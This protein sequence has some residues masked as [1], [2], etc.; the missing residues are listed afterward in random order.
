MMNAEMAAAPQVDAGVQ[1]GLPGVPVLAPDQGVPAGG[2]IPNLTPPPPFIRDEYNRRPGRKMSARMYA[3]RYVS[4][5]VREDFT[6]TI[7]WHS[8][9]LLHPVCDHV[10]G[11][12]Y[13]G[14]M[15]TGAGVVK[16]TVNVSNIG[17]LTVTFSASDV[18]GSYDVH[19]DAVASVHRGDGDGGGRF[20]V[21][22]DSTYDSVCANRLSESRQKNKLVGHKPKPK[23]KPKPDLVVGLVG[24]SDS[25]IRVAPELNLEVKI[26][27]LMTFDDIP[28]LQILVRSYLTSNTVFTLHGQV[29]GPLVF[30]NNNNVNYRAD[31]N[32]NEPLFLGIKFK[33]FDSI[34]DYDRYR[35]PDA[36]VPIATP[37]GIA[38]RSTITLTVEVN[39]GAY[40]DAIRKN[41]TIIPSGIGHS[42]H[43]SGALSSPSNCTYTIPRGADVSTVMVSVKAYPTPVSSIKAALSRLIREPYG[44]FEQTSATVYPMVMALRYLNR[45]DTGMHDIST[46]MSHLSSGYNKLTSYEVP[47]GGYEWFGQSPAHEALTAYGLSQ[48]I[49]MQ[50]AL[51]EAKLSHGASSVSFNV[52]DDMVKRTVNWLSSRRSANVTGG[53][54]FLRNPQSLD[55]FGSASSHITDAYIIWSLARSGVELSWLHSE[56]DRL[57]DIANDN[58]FDVI[59]GCGDRVR[60]SDDAY[61]LG[62]VSGALSAL[63]DTVRSKTLLARIISTHQQADGSISRAGSSITCSAGESLTLE[64]TSMVVLA[65]L[66][67]PDIENNNREPLERA[68]RYII[69]VCKDGRYSSTQ[70]TVLALRALVQYEISRPSG[71]FPMDTVMDLEYSTEKSR[72]SL[73]KT[74]LI[75]DVIDV[76]NVVV[77]PT[78]FDSEFSLIPKVY[79][80][81]THDH[82]TV[83]MPYSMTISCISKIPMSYQNHT[84]NIAVHSHIDDPSLGSVRYID[85]DIVNTASRH[86]S[87]MVVA[88]IPLSCGVVPVHEALVK[89]KRDDKIAFYELHGNNVILYWRGMASEST[90]SIS[91]PVVM[92]YSGTFGSTSPYVYEY[93]NPENVGYDVVEQSIIL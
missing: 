60:P 19:V 53:S 11:P 76:I 92:E 75:S 39:G 26:P 16:D 90:F 69:S 1:G 70:G 17:I 6:D 82:V 34:S 21:D 50:A 31:V 61:Y 72:R 77:P 37:L 8:G 63:R 84:L 88:V 51:K 4:K 64:T 7:L 28:N 49:D 83:D 48:F 43:C 52:D 73:S 65:L 29:T 33:P 12:M 85:I 56:V 59:S 32:A 23:P 38:W 54:M 45:H 81:S 22:I 35:L 74:S 78:K 42:I 24:Q 30:N 25:V 15:D 93:Y 2:G 91:I 10:V 67:L 58:K 55:T 47:G 36:L 27:D 87:G 44:C 57:Y 80:D 13:T 3:H 9:V 20:S 46:I 66:D 14:H 89:L 40:S 5:N 62:L 68:M 41:I 86:V 79:S 71:T 18:V